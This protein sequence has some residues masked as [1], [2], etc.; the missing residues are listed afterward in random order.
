MT[1]EEYKLLLYASL[2]WYRQKEASTLSS[3]FA[4]Q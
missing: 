1:A 2:Y 4:S 3:W